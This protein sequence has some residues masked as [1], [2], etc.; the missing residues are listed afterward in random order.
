MF[1]YVM[2]KRQNACARSFIFLCYIIS[3]A[4]NSRIKKKA[5]AISSPYKLSWIKIY[6]DNSTI[7][8]LFLF[9]AFFPK[10]LYMVGNIAHSQSERLSIF[11][12][13][14]NFIQKIAWW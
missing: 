2:V 1:I 7:F 14:K 12:S 4:S 10:V 9:F 13:N 11:N 8:C 6:E 5:Y 3:E